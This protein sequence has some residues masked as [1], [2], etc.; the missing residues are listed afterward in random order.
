MNLNLRTRTAVAESGAPTAVRDALP[1]PAAPGITAHGRAGGMHPGPHA[2]TLRILITGLPNSGKSQLCNSITGAYEIVSNYPHSTVEVKTRD[3]IVDGEAWAVTDTPGLH[4]LYIQS[5][6]EQVVRARLFS[7]PPD[8]LVQCVDTHRF[9][10]SLLLTADLLGLG[11]PLILVLTAVGESA[12]DGLRLD[13]AEL[14]RL[15]GVPVVSSPEPG[16]GVAELRRA[17]RGPL[18]PP[19]PLD[20]SKEIEAA[21]ARVSGLLPS[22]LPFARVLRAP[23]PGKRSHVWR[24]HPGGCL[25]C[26]GGGPRGDALA[27]GGQGAA[28]G[29]RPAHAVGR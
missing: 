20:Y 29:E 21:V 24:R 12:R 18:A 13:A 9:R 3:C 11:I 1:E 14:A 19:R 6:E 23:A 17:L 28:P 27:S 26:R 2:R 10:E 5:E 8:V 15:L 7:E 4:G 22:S 16:A 25:R